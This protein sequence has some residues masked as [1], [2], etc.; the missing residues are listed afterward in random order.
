MSWLSRGKHT[1]PITGGV[2]QQTSL[3]SNGM[4]RSLIREFADRNPHLPECQEYLERL[5][6]IRRSGKA[7]ALS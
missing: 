3:V 4:A 1:S 6:S 7:P 5:A 2:L